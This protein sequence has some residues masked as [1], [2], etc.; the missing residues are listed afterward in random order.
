[1]VAADIVTFLKVLTE[2]LPFGSARDNIIISH[3]LTGTRPPLPQNNQW[4]QGQTWLMMTE[5]WSEILEVRWGI[6]AI[7]QH[8]SAL[9]INKTAGGEE[10]QLVSQTAARVEDPIPF[11]G[12][13][14]IAQN[15]T[16]WRI[17]HLPRWFLR[18]GPRTKALYILLLISTVIVVLY[19]SSRILPLF[20][21]FIVLLFIFLLFLVLC[22]EGTRRLRFGTAI[23]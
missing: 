20:I 21:I 15:L 14:V 9:G 22:A 8:L 7:H 19:I 18:L 23:N 12:I 11:P 17:V 4:L 1:M 13:R 2:V 3:I 6:R 5:C 16:L 10:N